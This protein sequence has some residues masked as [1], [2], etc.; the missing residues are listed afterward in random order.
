[1][2]DK[3]ISKIC[4]KFSIVEKAIPEKHLG[5]LL[6]REVDTTNSDEFCSFWEKP[7]KLL[8]ILWDLSELMEKTLK[9][10]V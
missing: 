6:M 1:M 2:G 5:E 9:I 10:G 4:G 8:K 3:I 7:G